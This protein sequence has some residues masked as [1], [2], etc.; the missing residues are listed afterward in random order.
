MIRVTRWHPD[1]CECIVDFEW[2]DSLPAVHNIK[3]VIR[4]CAPHA[5]LSPTQLWAA[6]MDENPRKNYTFGFAEAITPVN[7]DDCEWSFNAKR[8]LQVTIRGLTGIH[9]A[10]LQTKCNQKFGPGKVKVT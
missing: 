9:K 4:A 10:Q 7:A 8:V 2:D 5:G 3:E 1:T 6:L